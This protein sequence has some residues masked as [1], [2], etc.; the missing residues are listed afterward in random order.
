MFANCDPRTRLRNFL[1]A[2][3]QRQ[4]LGR[5]SAIGGSGATDPPCQVFFRTNC[6]AVLV[7]VLGA[8]SIRFLTAL[9]CRFGRS[10]TDTVRTTVLFEASCPAVVAF[11]H[12]GK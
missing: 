5:P 8:T 2:L 4:S 6:P 9:Q 10:H 3:I 1:G 7:V 12:H 11:G